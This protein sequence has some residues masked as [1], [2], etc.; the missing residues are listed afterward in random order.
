MS[1]KKLAFGVF[2]LFM[3][4][5]AVN[6]VLAAKGYAYIPNVDPHTRFNPLRNDCY[7]YYGYGSCNVTRS[8]CESVEIGWNRWV[9]LGDACDRNEPPKLKQGS[10]SDIT[11]YESEKVV[12]SAECIDEDPVTASYSG[13]TTEM[14]TQTGYDDAGKYSET[15]TCTDSF[16]ES[17]SG[18]FKITILNKN[19]SP[20]FKLFDWA[21]TSPKQEFTGNYT[22]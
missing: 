4:I 21:I 18:D 13:W 8:E 17:V 3:A 19:R 1:R 11:V 12:I 15:V 7:Y 20:L 5:L 9:N 2:A 16:N 14:V 22:N 6:F 10:F